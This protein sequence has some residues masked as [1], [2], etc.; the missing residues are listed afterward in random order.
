MKQV[1]SGHHAS[2]TSQYVLCHTFLKV[3]MY[4]YLYLYF[5]VESGHDIYSPYLFS[6]THVFQ[7]CV[8]ISSTAHSIPGHPRSMGRPHLAWMDTAMK[9]MGSLGHT[10]QAGRP[11]TRLG[12]PRPDPGC[13]GGPG[14][15]AGAGVLTVL[16]YFKFSFPFAFP[17]QVLSFACSSPVRGMLFGVSR[18][19]IIIIIIIAAT[20][21]IVINQNH[22]DCD[23]G[24]R[25]RAGVV[26]R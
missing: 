19:I 20:N 3:V 21:N 7:Y 13:V 22:T 11:C 15:S 14:W 8:R 4:L 10:L 18:L 23:P 9:D 25:G 1:G 6:V 16:F 12:V 26:S 5:E 17:A 24:V 2:Y